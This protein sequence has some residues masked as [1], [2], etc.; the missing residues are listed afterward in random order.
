MLDWYIVRKLIHTG[1]RVKRVIRTGDMVSV[2]A[3]DKGAR[4]GVD[5]C[6]EL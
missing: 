1:E 3:V 5:P 4:L 2:K 6:S